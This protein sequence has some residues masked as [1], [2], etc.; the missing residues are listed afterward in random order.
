MAFDIAKFSSHLKGTGT[1][2]TNRY[3]VS[4]VPPTA[5]RSLMGGTSTTSM[6]ELLQFRAED[7]KLPGITLDNETVHRYGIGPMQRFATGINF[8]DSAITFLEADTNLIWRSF[9]TWMNS[10]IDFSGPSGGSEPSYS[11]EYK[12]YY[13]TDMKI[14]VYNANKNIS[15]VVILRDVFPI[16]LGDV[17]LG[18]GE[19]NQLFKINVGITFRDWYIEG[20]SSPAFNSGNFASPAISSNMPQLTTFSNG[21]AGSTAMGFIRRGRDAITGAITSGRQPP[22]STATFDAAG[23]VTSP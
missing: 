11:L 18:W 4:F 21:G 8:T 17:T 23:N 16:S 6:Q 15:M 13:V 19:Y 10:I 20:S 3:D 5:L 7:V 2:Q 1:L 9:T 14:T 12:K 22:S